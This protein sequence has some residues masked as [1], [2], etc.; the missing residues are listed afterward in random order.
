MDIQRQMEFAVLESCWGGEEAAPRDW[1]HFALAGAH[2]SGGSG[3]P[4]LTHRAPFPAAKASQWQLPRPKWPSW[5]AAGNP[6]HKLQQSTKAPDWAAVMGFPLADSGP[7]TPM[8]SVPCR[9]PP[10]PCSGDQL[11]GPG[12]P[13]R[14]VS[15]G[16]QP[17]PPSPTMAEQQRLQA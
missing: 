10:K 16:H 15:A 7:Q 5:G 6:P 9:P 17:P 4:A 8:C 12:P 2:G 1:E 13:L 3:V 14:G 11:R